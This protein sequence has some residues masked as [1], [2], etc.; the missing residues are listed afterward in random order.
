MT[1]E[2]SFRAVMAE[3][4]RHRR[5][6]AAEVAPAIAQMIARLRTAALTTPDDPPYGVSVAEIDA[7]MSPWGDPERRRAC[8]ARLA[9]AEIRTGQF[10]GLGADDTDPGSL[11]AFWMATYGWGRTV[12][13]FLDDPDVT[14]IKI[15]GTTVM[16]QGSR[17]LV[18]VPNAYVSVRE[19]LSRAEYLTQ[20]MGVTW[21]ERFP[22]VTVPLPGM[23]LHVTHSA[24]VQGPDPE[25]PGLLVVMRRGR[26]VPWG[27]SDLISRQMLD[28]AAA[29]L[30]VALVTPGVS[31]LCCGAQ[32]SGKTTMLECLLNSLAPREHLIIIEDNTNEF[33]LQSPLVTRVRINDTHGE[34]TSR[35]RAQVVR[36]MLRITPKR[37]IVGEI[38]GDEAG[39]VVQIAEGGRPVMT[40]IH[41][42]T[43]P[44]ALT[45][46]A[47]LAASDLPGN[48]FARQRDVAELVISRTFALVI[49]TRYA[50]RIQRR[51]VDEVVLLDGCDAQGQTQILPV[52]T[53][54]SA[55]DGSV[56]WTCHARVDET[57]MLV[58]N[59]GATQTPAAFAR[60]LRD[61]PDRL[62]RTPP[63]E[64]GRDRQVLERGGEAADRATLMEQA[65]Q[66]VRDGR[67]GDAIP[68]L[69]QAEARG[70]ADREI[71]GLVDKIRRDAP[72]LVHAAE[73]TIAGD[74]AVIRAAVD[75]WD[76]SA[77][78]HQ[79]SRPE[80]SLLVARI[81]SMDPQWQAAVTEVHTRLEQ[82]AAARG[83]I[84]EAQHHAGRGAVRQA[85]ECLR[86]AAGVRL[87][88]AL[89]EEMTRLL[90][91]WLQ[92]LADAAATPAVAAQY[93]RERASLT[94][95]GGQPGTSDGTT[96]PI[97]EPPRPR[98]RGRGGFGPAG[99]GGKRVDGEPQMDGSGDTAAVQAAAAP[100]EEM[101]PAAGADGADAPARELIIMG[102]E[103]RMDGSGDRAAARAAVAPAEEMPPAAGADGADGADWAAGWVAEARIAWMDLGDDDEEVSAPGA[104]GGLSAMPATGSDPADEPV[105][106]GAGGGLSA[107][108]A[109][110]SDPADEPVTPGAGTRD[111]A[112]GEPD[113]GGSDPSRG[114]AGKRR[115]YLEKA[116]QETW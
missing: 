112:G 113:A 82:V 91:G 30:L 21:N 70:G 115:T 41:A 40:T 75:R 53:S 54:R 107:M 85:V 42:A 2:V 3:E 72:A 28:T 110:G 25:T 116:L 108:P 9:G 84:E 16:A 27:M 45:R 97:G 57:G 23:R 62:R 102:G 81:R 11:D 56:T 76:L 77:A 6:D 38:R 5:T 29:E 83:A 20:S 109:T 80:P 63:L 58:W 103:P 86:S 96:A 14:E 19:P 22:A 114:E 35:S 7:M 36:E 46:L 33:S 32:D 8:F 1:V 106:P 4:R 68:V 64:R 59:D 90:E 47:R 52:I 10:G 73:E 44:A 104:G 15:N 111:A 89:S 65:R 18:V 92:D 66:A 74:L 71:I 79:V 95:Q 31:V 49:L 26:Q 60:A 12:Q 78:Q 101:P 94:R 61:I 93:A 50:E 98:Y 88:G 87:P 105:T 55:D 13:G 37:V 51:I 34:D 100:A 99:V 17:G 24:W 48:S 43:I 67:Y 69:T 39:P